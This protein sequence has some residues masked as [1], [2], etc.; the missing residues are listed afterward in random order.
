MHRPMVQAKA[1]AVTGK[2]KANDRLD[3]CVMSGNDAAEPRDAR[4][5]QKHHSW[6]LALGAS[7]SRKTIQPTPRLPPGGC[8]PAAAREER[9][10]IRR[11]TVCGIE[12]KNGRE[13]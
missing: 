12:R 6:M 4:S 7:G 13:L 1:Q 2:A 5:S 8:A 3:D 10:L 9:T 11:S